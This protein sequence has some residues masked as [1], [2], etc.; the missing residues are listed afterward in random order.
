MSWRGRAAALGAEL[1]P[2]MLGLFVLGVS[3][4]LA[5]SGHRPPDPKPLSAPATEFS[6]ERARQV[7]S[8]LL[9]SGAPHPVASQENRAFRERLEREIRALS[10]S[11]EVIRGMSCGRFGSCAEV[12]NVLVALPSQSERPG[13][14]LAA[15]YDSVP[16]SAGA[17]DDGAGVAALLEAARALLASGPLERP[18]WLLFTDGEEAGL[19]GAEYLVANNSLP[20]QIQLIVNLE[21][22]GIA[23]PSLLFETSPL[24]L[25][26][27]RTVARATDRPVMS[28]LFSSA[29]RS[30]PNDTDLSVFMDAGLSGLNYAFIEDAH[31]YHTPSDDLRHLSLA[32]LQHHGDQALAQSR[33]LCAERSKEPTERVVFFDIFGRWVVSFT[34]G[35]GLVL[36][37]LAALFS[38][39]LLVLAHRRGTI[40]IGAFAGSCLAW[41][42]GIALAAIWGLL[43][44]GL[45][46]DVL[47]GGQPWPAVSGLL[48]VSAHSGA[49]AALLG[50]SA[51]AGSANTPPNAVFA[52][53][54][55]ALLLTAA[56]AVQLPE[57]I[58][59]ALIPGLGLALFAALA[60]ARPVRSAWVL[61]A[62]G[63]LLVST[64]VWAPISKLTYDVIGLAAPVVTT[65]VFAILLL[66]LWPLSSALRTPFR[67]GAALLFL[68]TAGACAALAKVSPAHSEAVR[69]RVNLAHHTDAVTGQSHWLTDAVEL[70][71]PLASQAEFRPAPRVGFPSTTW[72]LTRRYQAMASRFGGTPPEFV[73]LQSR[74]EP[75]D[76]R[77]V[78]LRLEPNGKALA[79][80]LAL[81]HSVSAVVV[82]GE[83]A[84]PSAYG[85]WKTYTVLGPRSGGVTLRVSVTGQSLVE[86]ELSQFTG[87]LPEAGGPLAQS[88]DRIGTQSQNGDLTI[89][90]RKVVF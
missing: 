45:Y 26:F 28:S 43:L 44:S 78:E 27:V 1:W 4:A 32:S 57:A 22:R 61:A 81:P 47:A 31:H 85:E 42:G 14:A 17:A 88:R 21:A 75:D 7:L 6:A 11:P 13:L 60:L 12:E 33:V 25:D 87:G 76:T 49:L 51:A 64:L 41:L 84:V 54:F 2:F 70:P 66:P 39:A 79:L 67:A 55:G 30:L 69:P 35:F 90:S 19:L 59:V 34:T 9:G 50:A 52:G 86:G 58:Y 65:L 8:R 56:L 53:L 71:E 74:P 68:L 37:I 80:T 82:E 20:K 48:L 46:P 62:L 83:R 3:G 18:I 63:G 5:I 16:A 89:V 24:N 29:Y 10:L 40:S 38:A 77:T 72:G 73:V 23:G 36:S 15:H